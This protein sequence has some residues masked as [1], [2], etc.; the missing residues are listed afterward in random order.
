MT[1][2]EASNQPQT[3]LECYSL[4]LILQNA[5]PHGDCQQ[6]WNAQKAKCLRKVK[7]WF[8]FVYKLGIVW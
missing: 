1:V 4:L 6:N 8:E 3:N 7:I 2:S 5:A